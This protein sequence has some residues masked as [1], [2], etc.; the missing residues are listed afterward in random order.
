M[1][2]DTVKRISFKAISRSI[3]PATYIMVLFVLFASLR[4]RTFLTYMN[5]MNVLR[6]TSVLAIASIGMTLVIASGTIDLSLGMM[7][8]FAGVIS[9]F[10]CKSLALSLL[11][12]LVLFGFIGFLK[13][14]IITK[15]RVAPMIT[16]LTFMFFIRGLVFIIN[17]ASSRVLP[18]GIEAFSFLGKGYLGPIPFP[19]VIMLLFLFG[20]SYVTRYTAL[21]RHFFAA[22]GSAESARMMGIRVDR[23]Q[24]IAQIICSMCVGIAGLI[25]TSRLGS[26]TPLQGEEY[27]TKAITAAVLGGAS[28]AGGQ[29]NVFGTV[30]GALILSLISNVFN[31]QGDIPTAWQKIVSGG[32]LIV[33]VLLQSGIVRNALLSITKLIT[34]RE[35]TK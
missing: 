18:K 31:L 35:A 25:M 8:S 27:E 3:P 26:I 10:T 2:G 20:F 19:V 4:Y 5:I 17:G 9:V 34:R 15:L 14:L 13:G 16:T 12:I 32:M 22:G 30:V 1:R 11:V 7:L 33:I 24:I 29:G 23:V 21:G 28:L 6:Q